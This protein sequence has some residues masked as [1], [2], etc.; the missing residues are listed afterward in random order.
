MTL[1]VTNS[2]VEVV[3]NTPM[4]R[5]NS[6]GS[7][8]KTAIYCKLEFLNPGGSVK[9]RVAFQIIEDAEREGLLKPG[10]TVVEATS[11]NTGMGLALAA[12]VK[13]YK[14][15]FVMP[16]KMSGEK[17]KALRAFGSKVVVT[18]TAV[19]PEDPRSYYSVSRR[20]AE[21]APNGFYAN[22]YHNPSNPRAHY[23]STAPEIWKQLGDKHLDAI[24]IATGTGGTMTGIGQYMKEHHPEVK[25]V[26]V[27][28]V[29]SVLYD[30]FHTGQM[31][32]A[33]TYKVEGFGEDF[34][35]TTTDFS[36]V[37]D[38]VRVTDAECF[39]YARRLVRE[40]GLY[41]GGSGGGAVAGT[42]KWAERHPEC[43]TIVTILPDSA[44][45][46]LSKVFDDDWMREHGFLGHDPFQGC[47]LDLL[48]EKERSEVITARAD[49]PVRDVIERMK[50][51]DV[52]QLP[53][54]QSD[55]DVIGI[56]N[57]NDLLNFLL[58]ED[59]NPASPVERLV[60]QNYAAVQLN[61]R[62]STLASLFT[63]YPV[64]LVFERGKLSGILT[65][66]DFI[67][68]VNRP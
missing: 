31:T 55:G 38:M 58:S 39:F 14:T 64:V 49:D 27:D 13:G 66:I 52:S 51:F 24:I 50:R 7:H 65:K 12:A 46:Y 11:G 35:P 32:E 4:V 47:V 30:Y 60:E 33:R 3:G 1:S 20:I 61:T 2:I 59:G 45:R 44:S 57:D 23:L 18:P 25:I 56:V 53:V 8:L 16:D 15:V 54:V 37:D 21:E 28:P 41:T 68:F 22:Q 17:I 5:L 34:I 42:V 63:Q 9:D 10:G 62:L 26:G 6:I 67:D 40:E 48:N 29:G 19:A 36:V 43:Q